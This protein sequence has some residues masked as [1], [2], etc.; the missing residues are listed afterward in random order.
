MIQAV[1]V[2]LDKY[3]RNFRMFYAKIIGGHPDQLVL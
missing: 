3:V 1:D 2:D